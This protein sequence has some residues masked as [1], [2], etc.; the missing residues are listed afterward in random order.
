MFRK[1]LILIVSA[2]LGCK[3]NEAHNHWPEVKPMVI[4]MH[5]IDNKS[6]NH[7]YI[8]GPNEQPLYLLECCVNA[9]ESESAEFNFSG[10]VDCRLISLYSTEAYSTLLANVKNATADWQSSGRFLMDDVLLATGNKKVWRTLRLRNMRLTIELSNVIIVN[11]SQADQARN[12]IIDY[13]RIHELDLT[14]TVMRDP[15]AMSAL[16][17]ATEEMHFGDS[18][19]GRIKDTTQH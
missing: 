7:I 4:N 17:F 14:V 16:D 12:K 18:K 3:S 9:W 19:N 13:P 10:A 15:S 11:G 1:F 2:V 8:F 6:I 5:L